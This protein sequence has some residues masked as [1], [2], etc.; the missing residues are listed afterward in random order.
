MICKKTDELIE[1]WLKENEDKI[2]NDW[3]Q[4]IEIPSVRGEKEENAP[5]GLNCAKALAKG[6]ELFDREG[7]ETRLDKEN[8]YAIANWK[9]SDKVIGLFGH[10]DVVPVGD[11]WVYTQPFAPKVLTESL[12]VEALLTIKRVLL[13]LFTL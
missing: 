7:F 5:F 3:F 6:N 2:I 12:L 13:L 11:D 4:L 9:N 10:C 1:K 8:R